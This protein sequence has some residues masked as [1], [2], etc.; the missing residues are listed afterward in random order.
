MSALS[1]I[2]WTGRTW[3]PVVGCKKVSA[4]CNHCYAMRQAF[5]QQAIGT[6]QYQGL[7]VRTK[8]GFAWTG[9]ARFVPEKLLD[10]VRWKKPATIFVNS[11]SDLFHDDVTDEQ[12]DEI[13]AIMAITPRHTFQVLTK[14]PERMASYMA[15]LYRAKRNLIGALER[16]FPA[17]T[18]GT[19]ERMI[20]DA[21][22]QSKT[23]WFVSGHSRPLDNVWLGVSAE[24]Q[25][26]ADLRIPYLLRTPATIRFL[27]LEPL[28]G[29]I[30]LDA[31]LYSECCDCEGAGNVRTSGT[32]AGRADDCDADEC[33]SCEGS[34]L[35]SDPRDDGISWVIVGGESGKHARP[36]H[37]DW[38]RALRD[39]SLK[40]GVDFFFKQWGEWGPYDPRALLIPYRKGRQPYASWLEPTEQTPHSLTGW[41]LSAF[42]GNDVVA[43]RVGRKNAGRSLDGLEHNA[44]PKGASDAV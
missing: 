18:L 12:L 25:A 5:R 26:T 16:L 14:R 19:R 31:F 10:P 43:V 27:S 37:P 9:E 11:M 17:L 39:Q 34:G 40:A 4:G 41:H 42:T 20:S 32:F 22:D 6:K 3:N 30:D 24:D 23:E 1:K 7:T 44:M 13:F 21:L 2:E 33:R 28:L 15:E 8:D 35:S 36:I 29:G 38:A